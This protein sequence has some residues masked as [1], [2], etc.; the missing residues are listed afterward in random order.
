MGMTAQS[1]YSFEELF[2]HAATAS[3]LSRP[4]SRR[5]KVA[6]TL[7]VLLLALLATAPLAGLLMTSPTSSPIPILLMAVATAL[8][9][10]WT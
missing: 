10:G 2:V 6:L 8:F 9:Y 5:R 1:L 7:V 3:M 4:L